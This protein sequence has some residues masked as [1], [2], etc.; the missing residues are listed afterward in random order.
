[1]AVYLNEIVFLIIQIG[2]AYDHSKLIK[3]NQKIEHLWWAMLSALIVLFFVYISKFNW[4][5]GL[6]LIVE[7]FLFFSI[8]LNLFRR[9]PL[10]Y[11]N[12]DAQ[13]ASK[14]DK[15]LKPYYLIVWFT[16]LI[17]FIILQFY[18][19]NDNRL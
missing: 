9:L 12:P 19:A 10:F 11:I 17:I 3:N 5:F 15:L 13:N 14:I 4:L 8:A 6:T 16:C 7:R 18:I 1:M 2:L